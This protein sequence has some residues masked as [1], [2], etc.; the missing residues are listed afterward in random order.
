MGDWHT[1]HLFDDEHF[2]DIIMPRLHRQ[3]P[4]ILDIYN[5]ASIYLTK[6]K[7]TIEELIYL[8]NQ[9]ENSYRD[10]PGFEENHLQHLQ[11]FLADKYWIHDLNTFFELLVFST[12]SDYHPYL[13]T[14]KSSFSHWLPNI[15]LSQEGSSIVEQ[16]GKMNYSSI[17]CAEGGGIISWI[18]AS[19][20]L[21]LLQDVSK[22][23][24]TDD[25]LNE[26]DIDAL[27]HLATFLS[28]TAKLGM[29]LLSA[30]NL[31]DRTIPALKPF[32]LSTKEIWINSN[33]QG[34]YF[35]KEA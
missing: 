15:S 3:D 1:L 20:V 6:D 8:F 21:I 29:G 27:L 28:V 17:Y 7:P 34:L 11:E 25:T 18:S 24:V 4:R 10:Y 23:V 19:D 14:G 35:G 5:Q 30:V 31:S 16:L 2:Y 26:E 33:M 9:M 22:A 12:V 32:K 13:T